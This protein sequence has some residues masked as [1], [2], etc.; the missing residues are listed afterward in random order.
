MMQIF[1]SV[2]CLCAGYM[3]LLC[4]AAQLIPEVFA[5]IF[6]KEEALVTL[7][8]SCIQK[9]TLGLL[10]VAVQY[11]V[12]DGLTAM[13]QLRFALPIS[14][15]RKILYLVCVFAIPVFCP[16]ENVFYAETISD[17]VGA[18]ITVMVF[19]IIIAPGL[20]VKMKKAI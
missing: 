11:A 15:F 2:F 16:L 7:S 12:V 17:I 6:I 20:R 10:G 4:A 9:Y 14:F 8:A 19:V 3:L 1:K 5:R 18:G 13:G